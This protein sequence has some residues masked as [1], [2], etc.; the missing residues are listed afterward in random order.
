ME[1]NEEPIY[2]PPCDRTYNCKDK[3]DNTKV[4]NYCN[5][6]IFCSNEE[7]IITSNEKCKEVRE[8]ECLK[9]TVSG[10]DRAYDCDFSDDIPICMYCAGFENGE[11][12]DKQSAECRKLAPPNKSSS[13]TTKTTTV[14]NPNTT[15]PT[16]LSIFIII[17]V[18][19]LCGI[20]YS[21]VSKKNK[22]IK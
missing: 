11:C 9:D 4:C 18:L 15:A 17:G 19:V 10:C 13:T 20:I 7:C 22:F 12:I 3:D 2:V 21:V 6:D 16:S 14:S 1:T 8:V 5:D